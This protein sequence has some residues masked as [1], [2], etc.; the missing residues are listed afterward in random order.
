MLDGWRQVR[1]TGVG[2]AVLL[3]GEAGIGKSRIAS[4]LRERLEAEGVE[5][6]RVSMFAVLRQ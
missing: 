1:E 2:Q 6:L 3:R 4:A 5:L